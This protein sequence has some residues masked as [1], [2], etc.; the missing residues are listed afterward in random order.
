MYVFVSMGTNPGCLQELQRPVLVEPQ[1]S[2]LIVCRSQTF[3]SEQNMGVILTSRTDL[4]ITFKI[5]WNYTSYNY[6]I[7]YITRIYMHWSN[8]IYLPDVVA[9]SALPVFF[10]KLFVCESLVTD[11]VW[12]PKFRSFWHPLHCPPSP[13]HN[14]QIWKHWTPIPW[15]GRFPL[16][17]SF[18]SA[19]PDFLERRRWKNAQLAEDPMKTSYSCPREDVDVQ[20]SRICFTVESSLFMKRVFPSV[21][22]SFGTWFMKKRRP[23]CLGIPLKTPHIQNVFQS[24]TSFT[25]SGPIPIFP[26]T[27]IN[28]HPQLG[29]PIP[30]FQKK[31]TYVPMF[32]GTTP[33]SPSKV[34]WVHFPHVMDDGSSSKFPCLRHSSV[35]LQCH[36]L[37]W[38]HASV[39]RFGGGIFRVF[40]RVFYVLSRS[41]YYSVWLMFVMYVRTGI[42][43]DT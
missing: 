13:L 35:L 25:P 5:R 41:R 23:I 24:A 10:L 2:L 42:T 27:S 30:T 4:Y 21:T 6:I 38:Q 40:A 20:N 26:T 11:K 18:H 31:N 19:W 14:L 32:F 37:T 7:K 15:I 43:M 34:P 28:K 17:M 8:L 9:G 36:L 12:L 33:G 22:K 1:C 29:K 39:A 3:Q 16:A